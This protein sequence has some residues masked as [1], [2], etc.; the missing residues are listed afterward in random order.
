MSNVETEKALNLFKELADDNLFFK[1]T[2]GRKLKNNNI[3]QHKSRII[4][5]YNRIMTFMARLNTDN[6][7]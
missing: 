4:K 3:E 5:G 6:L 7:K 2:N 1:L